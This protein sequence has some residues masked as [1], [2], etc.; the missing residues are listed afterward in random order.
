VHQYRHD[1]LDAEAAHPELGEAEEPAGPAG[2]GEKEPKRVPLPVVGVMAG[3]MV[4]AGVI[5]VL[6]LTGFFARDSKQAP[7]QDDL[8]AA[9]QR[10]RNATYTLEGEFSRTKP[11]G[12]RLV[13]GALVAQRP[14]DELRRQLGGTSGRM[15]GRRVNC[16]TDPAGQFTCAPGAEVGSWDEMVAHELDNL[17]SYFD[18]NHPVY[19]AT[20]QPGGC[21]ELKLV[22]ALADPPYGERAVM[23]F[24]PPSGAMRSIEIDHAGGVVDLLE[25][26]AVRAVK[27]EDF[28]LE[29]NKAFEARTGGG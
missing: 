16:S 2:G 22:T 6:A 1:V 18:P 29:G 19:T 20:R 15:N 9:Y 26:S 5:A 28:S 17:R 14:P 25:A 13:S 4:A 10:S 24:D 12:S 8:V 7:A 11:D 27:P 21:F 23:C 3:L